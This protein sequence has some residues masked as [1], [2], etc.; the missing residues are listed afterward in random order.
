[1]IHNAEMPT[2]VLAVDDSPETL[3]FLVDALD[4]AGIT[5]LVASS[6]PAALQSLQ[7]ATPDV[8]LLDAV[9]PGM[10][11]FEVCRSIKTDPRFLHVPVIFMT[12]LSETQHVVEGF[13]A[14]G[15][16]Y[17]TKPIIADEIIARI[18]VHGKNARAVRHAGL[19]LEAAGRALL[20]ADKDGHI[21]WAT[22]RAK[23]EL[24]VVAA[25]AE[26]GALLP[27][28]IISWL[29]ERAADASASGEKTSVSSG[30]KFSFLAPLSPV[31]TLLSVK[32][33]KDTDEKAVLRERHGLTQREA[34][35][36][37][38]LAGGKSNRDIGEILS[39][40]SRTI[41]KYLEQI[42]TK[43]G[44]ENRTSAAAIALATLNEASA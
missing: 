27:D 28:D 39:L 11:G 25:H 3:R 18:L 8:I 12:G 6:G 29:K 43:L 38:W 37:L 9:M 15:V 35:V 34:E 5:V 21:L 44:V 16:D 32:R 1:M 22:A 36:L 41:D 42:Y 33:S 20:A 14:G 19:A 30:L 10:D 2:T 7:N 26:G 23:T 31:E 40:S 13:K 4:G 17:V 24:T